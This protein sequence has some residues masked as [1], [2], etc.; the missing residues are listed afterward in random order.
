MRTLHCV[1]VAAVVC[2]SAVQASLDA[3]LVAFYPFNGNAND[4]SGN[5]NH[6]TV[7]GVNLTVDRFGNENA[8]FDFDGIDDYIFIASPYPA[9][10]QCANALTISAWIRPTSI[11][12]NTLGGIFVGQNDNDRTGFSV[13]FEGR[14]IHGGIPGGIHFYLADGTNIFPTSSEGSTQATIGLDEWSHIVVTWSV[15]KSPEVYLNGVCV[16]QWRQW[17]PPIP[18]GPNNII[19]I[20][21]HD[22]STS[23]DNN[24]RYFNGIIDDIRIYN[25]SLVASEI[26]ELHNESAAPTLACPGFEPP[27]ANGPVKVKKNRTLP[28]K[29]ELFDS[30]GIEVIGTALHTSPV[31]Q[32]LYYPLASG[33]ATDVSHD[34][35]SSG[36]GTEGNQ[37]IFTEEGKWQFNL[38]TTNYTA[39][40]TYSIQI[41]SGDDTEYT[42]DQSYTPAKFVID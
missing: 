8:A 20:G 5:G 12:T 11:P 9:A 35:L 39:P 25:R 17:N 7:C 31:I 37:F 38:K 16:T 41:I 34:A 21:K 27:M 32:V 30:D 24:E 18:F 42:I 3:G 6:G 4:E 28:I 14:N 2:I 22:I 26:Q 13:H 29:T 40:G 19:T 23:W 36:Q 33:D 15:G 1:V 10:M